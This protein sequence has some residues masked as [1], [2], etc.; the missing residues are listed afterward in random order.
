M[1]NT[2]VIVVIGGNRGIGA[3]TARMA[4]AQGYSVLLTYASSPQKAEELVEEICAAGGKAEAFHTNVAQEADVVALFERAAVLGSVNAM[5]YSAG[6]TGAAS[7]LADVSA[8]TL[9]D[10]I[11]INLIGAM[12]SAREAVRHMSTERGG[13]GGSIVFI[14]SRAA[15]LGS[16]GEYIWYA[17]SK[18]GMDSAAIGL[19]KEVAAEGIR[20]NSVSPGP[21]ATGMLSAER[22]ALGASRVPMRRVGKP[23]EVADAV[24]YLLSDTA[25]YVTGA[26]IAVSG[27][28]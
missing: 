15:G 2:K 11:Q 14:S 20:V 1:S 5:V 17:A 27:G 23:E 18:G 25:S 28:A 3:A 10:V 22:Q 6:I 21:V 24:L 4:A 19:S 26:N 16:S 13:Q 12:L 8:D 9:N 7:K